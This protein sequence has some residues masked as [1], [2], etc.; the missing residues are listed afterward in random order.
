MAFDLAKEIKDRKM[1]FGAK[2]ALKQMKKGNVEVIYISADCHSADLIGKEDVRQLDITSM[3]MKEICK[4]PFGVSVIA[5]MK[6]PGRK[7]K[8]EEIEEAAEAEESVEKGAK[9][10]RRSKKAKEEEKE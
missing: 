6:E 9:K 1:F 8:K 4:K 5:L 3:E 10:K 7:I 2:E